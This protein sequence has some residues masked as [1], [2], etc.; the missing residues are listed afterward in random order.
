MLKN[1]SAM[2]TAA[3]PILAP[4]DLE[5]NGLPLRGPAQ[6]RGNWILIALWLLSLGYVALT[7]ASFHR[8]GVAGVAIEQQARMAPENKV[9]RGACDA[10]ALAQPPIQFDPDGLCWIN[11]T[12][13]QYRLG[14][15]RTHT[16]PWDNTPYGRERHW[17]QSLSWWLL[18]LGAATHAVTGAP[19]EMAIAQAAGWANPILCVLFLT[20]LAIALRRRCSPWTAGAFLVTLA[21][22][23]GVEWDFSYG[24][25]DHHGLHLMAFIGLMLGAFLGGMGWVRSDDESVDAGV[26]RGQAVFW[27]RVSAVCGGIGLWIGSTQQCFC[28]GVLGVG[29]AVSVLWLGGAKDEESGFSPELWRHWARVGAATS[30]ALYLIE[31]FPFRQGLRLEVNS[32][33][34]ALAWAGAGELIWVMAVARLDWAGARARA[35]ELALRAALGLAAVSALP[36]ALVFGPRAWW[37]LGDGW[38]WRSSLVISEQRPWLDMHQPL[39]AVA[40]I[41]SFTGILLVTLPALAL[42]ALC[43]RQPPARRA[44][45]LTALAGVAV[46]LA[47]TLYQIRWIGFLEVSLAFL[48][49]LVAPSLAGE[50]RLPALLLA[51]AAPGWLGFGAHEAAS[52]FGDAAAQAKSW[53]GEMSEWKEVAWNLRLYGGDKAPA[54][55]MAPSAPSPVLHYYG[56]VETVG[57][58][59]WENL[60]GSHA[61]LDFYAAP[62]DQAPQARRIVRERGLDFVV[63]VAQPSF[64]LEMQLLDQGKIDVASAKRTLAFR[65]GNPQA[66]NYPD[67]LEPLPLLD[68]PLATA[69]GVRL[70]RVRKD[71]L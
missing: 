63:A 15:W 33:F 6:R 59:Y 1:G 34:M 3:E 46:F 62:G 20:A 67:W 8:M 9:G 49:M 70:F 68:A 11:L 39:A 66:R 38:M 50:K 37:V 35:G 14:A 41:W 48:L 28:V 36:L 26:S 65:L 56:G 64:V 57:S 51:L 5:K 13:E 18:L 69:A 31:Y 22:S 54:R 53:V 55:V 47:W 52:Y 17:S 71:R 25:P 30:F 7:A 32:P 43:K 44:A 23:W 19:M 12:Q 29:A 40:R 2:P 27:L 24:R 21:A 45:I 58:Y 42:W 10:L 60:A 61:V 16:F 4:L